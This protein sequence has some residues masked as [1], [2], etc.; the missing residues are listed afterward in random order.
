MKKIFLLTAILCLAVLSSCGNEDDNGGQIGNV[1][2]L[3]GTWDPI[4][5]QG[6]EDPGSEYYEEWNQD[7][8][9]TSPDCWLDRLVISESTFSYW[10]YSNGSWN[11]NESYQGWRVE[12]NNLYI[13]TTEVEE[14]S[15][16]KIVTLTADKLVIEDTDDDYYEL[17][18]YRKVSE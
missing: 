4:H 14:L 13:N 12:N 3:Y 2:L 1:T 8:D 10:S 5:S 6:Y 15:C 16:L 17:V 9:V 18:T 7:M 11:I